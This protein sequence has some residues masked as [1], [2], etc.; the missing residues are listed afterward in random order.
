[1]VNACVLRAKT[2]AE[3][4][5]DNRPVP[6]QEQLLTISLRWSFSETRREST[7]SAINQ[8]VHCKL[9]R[10]LRDKRQRRHQAF[11]QTSPRNSQATA[12][13]IYKGLRLME[14]T[15]PAAQ[16]PAHSEVT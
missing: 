12:A 4:L 7:L 14:R 1:M 6:W 13:N 9:R 5:E 11:W 10:W 16:A 8:Y 15:R 2:H 3:A